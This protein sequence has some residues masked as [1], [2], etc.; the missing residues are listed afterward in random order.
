MENYQTQIGGG[1]GCLG[2][3]LLVGVIFIDP[4]LMV[5]AF[6]AIFIGAALMWIGQKKGERKEKEDV[7]K[8]KDILE[9]F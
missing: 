4:F 2:F 1:I 6:P 5:L 3:I 8:Q 9:K 7:E